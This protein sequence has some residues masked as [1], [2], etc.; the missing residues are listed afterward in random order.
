MYNHKKR[1]GR[2]YSAFLLYR[3]V[4]P[5]KQKTLRVDATD[6]QMKMQPKLAR[7][8]EQRARSALCSRAEKETDKLV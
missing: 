5:I 8:S 3:K 1:N 7:I 2:S 4:R 6:A